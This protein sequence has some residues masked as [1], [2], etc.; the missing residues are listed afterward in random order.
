MMHQA[1]S[2]SVPVACSKKLN[3]FIVLLSYYYQ[4]IVIPSGGKARVLTKWAKT[5]QPE[6]SVLPSTRNSTD[7][8]KW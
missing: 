8:L 6:S 2:V 1:M 7:P 3:C 4:H 5:R